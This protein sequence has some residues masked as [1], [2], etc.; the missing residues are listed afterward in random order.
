MQLKITSLLNL[1]LNKKIDRRLRIIRKKIYGWTDK[2]LEEYSKAKDLAALKGI[3][4]GAID[5]L[6]SIKQ[7]VTH[8]IDSI[9]GVYDIITNPTQVYNTIKISTKEWTELYNYALKTNPSLAGEM[10]GYMVGKS[11]V[12][13]NSG[14]IISGSA[15]QVVSK[16]AKLKYADKV[17]NI[18]GTDVNKPLGLGSTDRNTPANL[19]EKL[20]LE[21]VISNPNAG[22]Q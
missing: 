3:K 16:V 14:L 9:V 19:N 18:K 13:L 22:R 20:A 8:P 11:V 1:Y 6:K 2:Q 10:E 15:V 12:N 4:E 5:T 7:L 17:K 21:Q